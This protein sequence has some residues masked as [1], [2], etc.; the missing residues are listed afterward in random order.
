MTQQ[1]KNSIYFFTVHL[2]DCGMIIFSIDNRVFSESS[3]CLELAEK[4]EAQQLFLEIH[5]LRTV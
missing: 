4:V 3:K 1:Q 2:V 5:P